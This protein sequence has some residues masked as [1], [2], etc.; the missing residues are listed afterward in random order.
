M[1]IYSNKIM[2]CGVGGN[3]MLLY[4]STSKSWFW[5]DF[6]CVFR[7]PM[8]I[9]SLNCIELAPFLTFKEERERDREIVLLETYLIK[10]SHYFNVFQLSTGDNERER[11]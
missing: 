5:H 7:T 9:S 6:R 10:Y 3:I 11:D 8:S 4:I 1:P 2:L